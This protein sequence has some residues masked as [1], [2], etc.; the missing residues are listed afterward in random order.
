M[1]VSSGGRPPDI[2]PQSPALSVESLDEVDMIMASPLGITQ[3]INTTGQ[4]VSNHYCSQKTLLSGNNSTTGHIDNINSQLKVISQKNQTPSQEIDKTIHQQ[5]VRDIY[6]YSN[7]CTGPYFIYVENISEGFKGKLNALKVGD[8]ILSNWPELDNKIKSIESIGR[9]RVRIQ[10]KELKSANYMLE[11]NKSEVFTKNNLD[12]YLPKFI[13]FRQGVIRGI[14]TEY[15]EESI[16]HKIKQVDQHCIFDV[17]R[18]IRIKRKQTEGDKIDYI[19]TQTC[20]VTFK[21][22]TLP[23]YISINKVIFHVEPYIQKVLLCYN[24][25]RYGHLGKQCNSAP[26]CNKCA[27]NHSS[28]ECKNEGNPKCLH[29]K[30]DHYTSNLKSCPEFSRQKQIKAAMSELNISYN[31]A[32][33]KVPKTSYASIVSKTIDINLSQTTPRNTNNHGNI[34]YPVNY[35]SEQTTSSNQNSQQIINKNITRN[36]HYTLTS[37]V[38]AKRIRPPSPNPILLETQQ[39]TAPYTLPNTIGGVLHQSAYQNN[40]HTIGHQ[41]NLDLQSN[42][43]NIVLDLVTYVISTLQQ[44][45]NFDIHKIDLKNIIRER[46]NCTVP[47]SSQP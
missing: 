15:T 9:N 38:P 37:R 4:T 29:C 44:N 32:S 7:Y 5:K 24:C 21:S 18:V 16:Q 45:N 47:S 1:S 26:R 27:E 41:S 17:D 23:K 36:T 30:G 12:L 6:K 43:H 11:Q 3:K 19:N 14:S 8:I 22:Q 39:M 31:D 2:Q 25:Y 13:L 28:Q 35:N 33:K 42:L 10:F 34:I 46:L 40:V 20:I